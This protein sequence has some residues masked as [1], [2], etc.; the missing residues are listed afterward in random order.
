LLAGVSVKVLPK[1]T[2]NGK[3]YRLMATGLSAKHARHLCSVLK[4]KSQ[5]CIVVPPA[6][7]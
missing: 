5:P 4:A 2:A 3:L 7:S 1:A 6:K